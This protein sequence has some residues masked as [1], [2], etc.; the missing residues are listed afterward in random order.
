M[1]QIFHSNRLETLARQFTETV[2]RNR[3]DPFRPEQVVVQNA[4]MGRWLSLQLATHS[5]IAANL[6]YL[7]PA[8]ITWELLRTVLEHVPERDPCSPKLLRWRL[9]AELGNH[10]EKYHHDLGHY[11]D[12]KTNM[13][14]QLAKQIATVFDGY[15]FFRPDW[16]QRWEKAPTTDWQERLW[17]NVVTDQQLEHW[18]R[19]QQRFI[20]Q[21]QTVN[22]GQLPARI[23]FF[24]VPALSPAYL[25]MM[26]Q[27][28]E[29]TDVDFYVMNPSLV[30]WGDIE[31][32]KQ[33]IKREPETQE[34][35]TVGNPLLA[36]WGKQG[37]DFIENLRNLEPYPLEIDNFTDPLDTNSPTM[38]HQIQADILNLEGE[39]FVADTDLTP[40]QSITL[41]SCHSPMREIEVLYDQ[42][43]AALEQDKTLTPA[44]IVVMSPEI[45]TY[46]PFIEAV[47]SNAPVTLPF[48]IADQ[49]FS[50]A[51]N[52]SSA[53]IQL[54]STPQT[55]FE[56]EVVFA[57]LEYAE[58]RD[59]TG[60]DET[61]IQQCRDWVRQ[62]NI[63]RG[64]DQTFDRQQA[65][66]TTFEHTWMY[67]L[68]RLMLG[69]MLPGEQLFGDILPFNELEGSQVQILERF[70]QVAHTLFTLAKWSKA[71]RP[72]ADW[73]E[74]LRYLIN[75]LFGE[76]ADT[77]QVFQALDN[78]QQSLQQAG[79][80]QHLPWN[81][82]RDA[83]QS[84]LEQS[85]QAEGFLGSGITFCTLMPM[86]SVPFKFVALL[87]MQDGGFPRQDTRLSFD[88]LAHSKRRRGDR[89]RRDEDRYLFLESLLSA[90]QQLYISY[91]GQ[92]VLTNNTIMP[93][94]LVSELLD[95]LEKRFALQAEQLITRHP[96][97][98]FS[99]RYFNPD[100]EP[101]LF[102]YRRELAA[103]HNNNTVHQNIPPFSHGQALPELAEHQHHITLDQLISFYRRPARYFLTTRFELNLHEQADTLA[104]REPF[105]VEAFVDSTIS[106]Q[107]LQH[108]EQH[109]TADNSE[110]ILRAQG[111]LPH[112]K[113]GQLIFEDYYEQVKQL[114]AQLPALPEAESFE[115]YL[116]ADPL[117]LHSNLSHITPQ[118]RHLLLFGYHGV[119]QWLAIWLQHLAMNACT[120]IP[121]DTVRQTCVYTP[122]QHYHLPPLTNSDARQQLMELMR[123]YWQGLHQPLPFFPKS[124][125]KMYQQSASKPELKPEAA[126]G[127][128]LGNDYHQGESQ[129]VEYCLLYRD[130]SPFNDPQQ[131]A[132][133]IEWS[134]RILGG[135][136]AIRKEC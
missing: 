3:L 59:A 43:L 117:E 29:K 55:Q 31:S 30:Y 62:V 12:D 71:E 56:A 130:Q 20:Q 10:P 2:T 123:G 21:L 40:D 79:F 89:S 51:K 119:W 45:D 113:P 124:A 74:R 54:L 60:L 106:H 48:S 93:S 58:I 47:F 1:L 102:S 63:R 73:C 67:G 112:G 25:E 23:S 50:T 107:I 132:A 91:V 77:Y 84:Q 38:L 122:E 135:L 72:V 131:I 65:E 87:G 97:Q 35:I 70:Q 69:Y 78:L 85:N 81:V 52:I 136:F 100:K 24:S 99:P 129:K 108:L 86:R 8:E 134:T 126:I 75:Q 16:I 133:F 121:A 115:F 11:L 18:V 105:A 41:H 76:D 46:A 61:Q 28:A 9:L 98:A 125:W 14:W 34:Y 101:G 110:A 22:T 80:H 33:K 17:Q 103:L 116:H 92:N 82:F 95:Y 39:D 111:L 7:F 26:A 83:L 15:L 104:E 19:L 53:C 114:H 5:G 49:R 64:I 42:L 120:T 13:A 27:V 32:R 68:D 66:P 127:E 37:R 94:V 44:D 128:W 88:K 118:G 109:F 96:L 36:S 57:L 4:G 90:R 6:R